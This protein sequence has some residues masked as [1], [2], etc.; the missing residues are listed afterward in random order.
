MNLRICMHGVEM[1]PSKEDVIAGGVPNSVIRLS[2]ALTN[3]GIKVAIVTND[4]KFRETGEK[5]NN[6]RLSCGDFHLLLINAK[7]P[8]IAYSLKYFFKTIQ[9]IKQIDERGKLSVIHGHSGHLELAVVTGMASKFTKN[10]AVHTIY[11]PVRTKSKKHLFYKHLLK[12]VKKII[13]I[14]RSLPSSVVNRNIKSAVF[15]EAET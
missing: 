15:L 7:Y 2:N 13:A 12:D 3:V 10:P 6:F 11:C 1:S 5:T 9:K 8:S 4:R 14:F